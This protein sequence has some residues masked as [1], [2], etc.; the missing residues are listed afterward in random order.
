[1]FRRIESA[2]LA[3]MLIAAACDGPS[4]SGS[5]RASAHP[6]ASFDG[7]ASHDAAS[8]AVT[9]PI[10]QDGGGHDAP[11]DGGPRDA[12]ATPWNFA[13]SARDV[14][15]GVC[16]LE[17]LFH[18]AERAECAAPDAYDRCADEQ[19]NAAACDADCHDYAACA[20]NV[21]RPC[22]S[23][24]VIS[25]ACSTCLAHTVTCIEG[26][27]LTKI[28]C[29][30]S[31]D[32]G[33]AC[34]HIRSCCDSLPDSGMEHAGCLQLLELGKIGGET[35]CKQ[36]TNDPGSY[37]F[38]PCVAVGSPPAGDRPE[39]AGLPASLQRDP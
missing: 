32:A 37:C 17:P 21:A 30:S 27:C 22:D 9:T 23:S 3:T 36:A 6:D 12:H 13:I 7:A 10:A 5:P 2:A 38:I 14:V 31:P 15:A 33:G 18:L 26:A 25:D 34:E 24:C 39:C 28:Q 16:F 11:Q 29:A 1:M 4:G 19:C 8:D 20:A 35:L